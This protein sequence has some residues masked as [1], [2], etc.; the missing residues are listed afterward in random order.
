M[1]SQTDIP[2]LSKKDLKENIPF[3]FSILKLSQ[4]DSYVLYV[5]HCFLINQKLHLFVLP[6]R[7]KYCRKGELLF[8]N[9]N[10]KQHKG[11]SKLF[12][13]ERTISKRKCMT[14]KIFSKDAKKWSWVLAKNV[15]F[16]QL[17]RRLIDRWVDRK[18][19]I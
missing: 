10:L 2:H 8:F 1:Q 15:W 13:T 18:I 5:Q 19:D 9:K 3:A 11:L 17:C 6:L 12:F 7:K 14:K 4:K 16:K